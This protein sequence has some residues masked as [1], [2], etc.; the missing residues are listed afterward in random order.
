[1]PAIYPIA[2]SRVSDALI[3]ARLISQFEFDQQEMVRL[4]DQVGTGYRFS[5]PSQDAPAAIR[6]MTLQRLLEQKK[7]AKANFDTTQSFIG[8]SDT[9]LS[10]ASELL[11]R[12]RAIAL[13]AANSPSTVEQRLVLRNE[14]NGTIKQFLDIGNRKFR[15]RYL[16]AGSDA[17]VQPFTQFDQYVAYN[18]NETKLQNFVDIDFLAD[19][20]ITGAEAFGAISAKVRGTVDVNP[21]LTE[22][23]RLADLRSGRGISLGSFLVSD[24]TTT[25]T[26]DIS[27]AETVGDVIELIE[28]NPPDGREVNVTLSSNGLVVDLDDAL[29]GNLTIREVE[30]GTTAAELGIIN[31]VGVGTTPLQGTDLDPTLRLTTRLADI[32]GTRASA[33]L[34]SVGPDNDIYIE[35]VS[36]GAAFNNVTVQYIDGVAVGNQAI[37]TYDAFTNT[38][39]IDISPGVTQAS[40]VVAAINTTGVFTAELDDKLDTGNN[41][42]GIVEL[43]ATATTAG[44][45]GEDLDLNSG[46]Q[47]VNGGETFTLT[48]TGAET[49]EDLLNILN[50]SGAGVVATINENATGIDV[51]SRYSGTDFMIGENGG[52]TATQLGLRSLTD[53][54]LISDLNYGRGIDLGNGV[55]FIIQRRDGVTLDIDITGEETVGEILDLINNHPANV[56]NVVTA[57]LAQ[58]GNGI[59]LVDP[60]AAGALDLTVFRANS[61]ASWDLGLVPKNQDQA[62]APPPALGQPQVLTGTDINPLEAHGVFNSLLRLGAAIEALDITQI[63]RS[64]ESLD[65]NFTEL[66]F[67]RADLGAKARNLDVMKQRI[68]REDLDLQAALSLEIDTDMAKAISD[69]AA[70]Q[71]NLAASLK[72]V[73]EILQLTVFDFL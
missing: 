66:S 47:I 7:Q 61:F 18:G 20:S 45:S 58:F 54:T 51:R 39:T 34:N 40:T 62:V 21:I 53:A 27:N 55:D 46:I 6:A 2:S 37:A 15:G 49:V 28:D 36:N 14:I 33:R 65:E 5:T 25:K 12:V 19:T 31:T 32:L 48:F 67:V 71:A 69:L 52:L 10:G 30:G 17:T 8:A 43:A 56:G 42:I 38:L 63:A 44:G 29:G 64:M 41:G 11:I 24:G 9:A 73:G 4:Q 13:T 3:Q 59:E 50:G 60:N 68:D 72:L 16:F 26:I 70:R 1:M 22:E 23:T 57:Q 35:A